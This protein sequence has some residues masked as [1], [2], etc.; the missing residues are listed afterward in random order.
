MKVALNLYVLSMV[1]T[2]ILLALTTT[3]PALAVLGYIFGATLGL[4]LVL[5]FLK[6]GRNGS[7]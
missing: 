6:G 5:S 3:E 1:V 7:A 4:A 2:F